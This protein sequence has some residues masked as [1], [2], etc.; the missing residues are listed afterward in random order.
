MSSK[1]KYIPLELKEY[2]LSRMNYGHNGRAKT[3]RASR[4]LLTALSTITL[5]TACEGNYN[6][7]QE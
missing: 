3:A 4:D 1:K 2:W 7:K 6:F 5:R